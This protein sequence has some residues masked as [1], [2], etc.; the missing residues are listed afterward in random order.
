MSVIL[1][2]PVL[3]ADAASCRS[4]SSAPGISVAGFSILVCM[5]SSFPQGVSA[6]PTACP[7]GPATGDHLPAGT[8]GVYVFDTQRREDVTRAPVERITRQQVNQRRGRI[9]GQRGR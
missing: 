3:C 8:A 4:A 7:A 2:T 6:L 5:T 1:G 9:D